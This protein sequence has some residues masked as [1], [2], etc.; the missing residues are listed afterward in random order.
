M[1]SSKTPMVCTT[2]LLLSMHSR[3]NFQPNLHGL[4]DEDDQDE[5]EILDLVSYDHEG[6][7]LHWQ[8]RDR[9]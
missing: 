3:I 6:K 9:L 1:I 7:E 8:G 5:D 2:L 4:A